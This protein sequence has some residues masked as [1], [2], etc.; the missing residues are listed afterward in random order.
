V[1]LLKEVGVNQQYIVEEDITFMVTPR[2]NAASRMGIPMEAFEL[3]ST[4]DE[5]RAD[6]LSKYLHKINDERKGY[7]AAIVKE[8]KKHIPE[9][10]ERSNVFV[11][12]NPEWKPSILGIA[13]TSIAADFGGPVFLWGR[14]DGTD[15]K[16]SCRSD[17]S[18]SVVDLMKI[19]K[20]SF[21]HYGG[22][23]MSGGFAVKA[24]QIHVL[25]GKLNDAY[26]ELQKTKYIK[27]KVTIDRQFSLD[28]VTPET[29]SMI[30]KLGPFGVDNP[31]PLFL[32][33]NVLVKNVKPFGKSGDHLEISFSNSR[34][35]LVRAIGFYM[36]AEQFGM[37]VRTDTKINL[38]ATLEKS[39]FRNIPELRLRIIDVV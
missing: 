13:A 16:G 11:M 35:R 7:V 25:E 9:R 10:R 36:N 39:M 22:H 5:G 26:N 30:E 3:L 1:R 27:P 6:V 17:G 28:E 14:E 29:W 8:A 21:E 33:E 2:I 37:P 24:D 15:L 38:V 4:T 23:D 32:F 18:V 20:D 19:A 34:G 12:G 31:K